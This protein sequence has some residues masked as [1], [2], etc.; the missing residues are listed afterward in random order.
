[1]A[2]KTLTDKVETKRRESSAGF[3]FMNLYQCCPRKF[4]FRY[5]KGWR[6]QF[7]AEP[8]VKGS[9]FHEGKATFYLTKNRKKAIDIAVGI[10]EE[11]KKE[12][13]SEETY[14]RIKEQVPILLTHW[15][16]AF[17]DYDL[18]NYDVVAVE[19]ELKVPLE[20]SDF[21]MTIRPDTILRSKAEK[22]V[23][24]ME[25]KTSGFS[26]RITNEAVYFGDQATSYVWG[27]R[28]VMGLD[29]YGVIPDIA[30]WN[31][32]AKDQSN[33]Q[34]IRGD[35]IFRDEERCRNFEIQVKQIL[36]DIS[37]RAE[38]YKRRVNPWALFPRNS[39]YC[40]SFSTPCDFSEICHKD[41]EKMKKAPDGFM[42]E[43][44]VRK[45]GGYVED[46]ISIV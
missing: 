8:L 4:Y 27:V 34:M 25:T 26:H 39:H 32:K 5:L 10:I 19:K 24:I 35:V 13:A 36:T 44:G 37:Q 46:A 38:A 30:Y 40:L 23:F 7:T 43:G 28:K 41:C 21:V 45:L 33:I 29:V 1:M 18:K 15:F 20:G 6:N 11:S 31:S 17:G 9:A 3:H 2:K 14:F 22:Y 42:K 16:D 12:L